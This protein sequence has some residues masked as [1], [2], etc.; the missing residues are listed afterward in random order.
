MSTTTETTLNSQILELSQA[1]EKKTR[2]NDTHYWALKDGSPQWMTDICY[3]CHDSSMP[4][5]IIYE[6]IVDVLD[7]LIGYD[8]DDVEYSD[9]INA[10]G[11]FKGDTLNLSVLGQNN[12]KAV[13]L[14][15]RA[16][17]K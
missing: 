6:G 1:F 9:I 17:W 14:M 7:G 11:T 3:D 5:D 12:P 13:K 15:D 2:D 10:W 8:F 4:S 16:G